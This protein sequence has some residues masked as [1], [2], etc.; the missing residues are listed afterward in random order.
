MEQKLDK[1]HL[2]EYNRLSLLLSSVNGFIKKHPNLSYIDFDYYTVHDLTLFTV[3]PDFNFESLLDTYDKLMGILPAIK[4]IFSKPIINLR[5]SN[6]VLPVEVVRTI[7]QNTMNH[8]S[9]HLENVSDIT[10]RGI[11][12]RKLL[13]R[14]YEDDYSIYENVVF[15][16]FIDEILKYLRKNIRSIKDLVYAN[17]IMEFNLLERI[18]HLSY[19]LAIGKLHTGYVRDFDRYCVKAKQLYEKLLGL[20]DIIQPRLKKPIYN[21]NKHRNKKLKLKKTNIFISQKDYHAVYK[22]Y[23]YLETNKIIG[24]EEKRN[25]RVS[26]LLNK[27]FNY[28]LILTIFSIGHFD[29]T[30]DNKIK[31]DLTN[32]DVT[33]TFKKWSLRV[34][35]LGNEGI[36]LS[37][38][39][40]TTYNIM[41]I[42][43]IEL[44]ASDRVVKGSTKFNC[45]EII[46]LSPFEEDYVRSSN[47]FV[48]IESIE[49]FRRIQQIILRG[50]IYSSNKQTDCPFCKGRLKYNI[51]E[52]Q[53]ECENC[54]TV[55]KI[56][57]CSEVGETYY[58]T[59]ISHLEDVNLQPLNYSKNN[60]WLYNRK[61]ESRMFFRN[62]TKVDK[63]GNIIC[64]MCGKV[65]EK[66]DKNKLK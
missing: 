54:R 65:H 10:S 46:Y 59:K 27:Y 51:Q 44:R 4:R 14:I 23:K 43:S 3:E 1:R 60:E 38:T 53:Y 40:D 28:C 35:S 55:V 47:C 41:L 34:K 37:V 49:S 52:Q 12:P 50:M 11:K 8:L 13:T 42:P 18:N 25:V 45:D 22:V 48:S 5:D 24:V 36:L 21:L 61:I 63:D 56:G 7:N 32:L 17:E 6:D 2:E 66:L 20:E 16:N 62:I 29:F 19:F 31:M 26:T 58:Y 64:P 57:E 33:F 39:K 30:M 15:C 9:N